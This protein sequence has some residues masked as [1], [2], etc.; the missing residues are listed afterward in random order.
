MRII[1]TEAQRE[2]K[3]VQKLEAK[4]R[5]KQARIVKTGLAKVSMELVRVDPLAGIEYSDFRE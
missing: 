3:A 1:V 5:K 2:A 4:K